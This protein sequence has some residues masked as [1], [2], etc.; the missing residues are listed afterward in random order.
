MSSYIL[1]T[2][3]IQIAT[4]G[5]PKSSSVIFQD[6]TMRIATSFLL[7]LTVYVA[8]RI[9]F[10]AILERY[11]AN[12]VQRFV[13]ICSLANVSLFVL[14]LETFGYYVHGRYNTNNYIYFINFMAKPCYSL[15]DRHMDSQ[16]PTCAQ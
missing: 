5:C 7:Y 10:T 4:G 14:E 15:V 13:D 3:L 8:Q 16:T 6:A 1:N 9:L 12:S 2:S 11:F